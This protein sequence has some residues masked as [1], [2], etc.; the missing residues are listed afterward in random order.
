MNRDRVQTN[1][2]SLY[3]QL[4]DAQFMTEDKWRNLNSKCLNYQELDIFVDQQK[5]DNNIIFEVLGARLVNSTDPRKN[6]C[7]ILQVKSYRI[8]SDLVSG[9]LEEFG[10]LSIDN[11]FAQIVHVHEN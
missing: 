8:I 7:K 11:K 2:D 4:I 6:S 5:K 3:G 9:I 10:I 1:R